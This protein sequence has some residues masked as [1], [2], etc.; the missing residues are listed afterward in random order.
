MLLQ[1]HFGPCGG[2]REFVVTD[3]VNHLER[4]TSV[5]LATT[6]KKETFTFIIKAQEMSILVGRK[7]YLLFLRER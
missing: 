2:G 5:K 6:K 3:D 1:F 7:Q 4:K